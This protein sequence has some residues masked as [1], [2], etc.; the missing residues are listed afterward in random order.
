MI[1]RFFG[2][3]ADAWP[4]RDAPCEVRHDG[5]VID[6]DVNLAETVHRLVDHLLRFVFVPDVDANRERFGQL[7]KF[8]GCPTSSF[9]V[10]IRDDNLSLLFSERSG[11]VTPNALC[12]AGNDDDFILQHDS[13]P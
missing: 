5:G 3:F 4:A 12:T 1:F 6:Q 8:A 9:L 10:E 2:H 11:R 13:P 7:F